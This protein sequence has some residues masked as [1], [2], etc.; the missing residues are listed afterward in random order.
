MIIHAT[1]QSHHRF[2]LE[3]G[4]ITAGTQNYELFMERGYNFL[5]LLI[6]NSQSSQI[7]SLASIDA[8]YD[9]SNLG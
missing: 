1:N 9:E 8:F 4:D 5:S 3:S 2:E 6:I 7:D